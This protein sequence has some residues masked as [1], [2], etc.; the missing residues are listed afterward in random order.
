MKN[1]LIIIS[2]VLL[3]SGCYDY[4]EL[5]DMSV[6]TGIGIDY[7]D[8]KYIV[9]LEV[10]KSVKDASSNQIETM[11]FT[12]EDSNLSDAFLNAKSNSDK[13][14]YTEYVGV[15]LISEQ[16][17][18]NGIG[19]VV[20]YL[21]RDTTINTNYYMVVV[22][23]P[24]KV[25]ETK[26]DNDSM[27]NV[28]TNTINYYLDGTDFDDLDIAVSYMIES[29]VDI[30]V[31]NIYLDNNKVIYKEIAYF[32]KDKLVG[33]IDNKLYSLLC[34]DSSN[35]NFTK[36]GNTISIYKND[37]NYE[38]DKDKIIININ[39]EGLIKEIDK[40][41]DLEK[42][43][44]YAYLSRIINKDIKDEVE[45]FL[46]ET[47]SKKSDLLGLKDKYYKKYKK[48]MDKIDYEVKVNIKIN[49]NGTIY[50]VLYDK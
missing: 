25:L 9:S 50:G 1:I 11:V 7:K 2:L 35:V 3:I 6:V 13:Y 38:V 14:V 46:E 48:D 33:K 41:I 44:S 20:D 31:P 21:I 43:D 26:V 37:V 22:D 36:N 8:N 47:L 4:R 49:K 10:T 28:I 16:L 29:R 40:K 19:E 39:G 32:N 34:L 23:D 17:A 24:V 18:R 15:L 45:M 5:N 30:A 42:E 27:S 12:G